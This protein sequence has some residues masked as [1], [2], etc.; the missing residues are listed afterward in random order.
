MGVEVNV[1]EDVKFSFRSEEGSIVDF[2]RCEVS[3]GFMCDVVWIVV[4]GFFCNGVMDV[5]IYDKGF[6]FVEG[7][8]LGGCWIG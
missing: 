4:V 2:S 3:F 7:V 8:D 6:V 5:E 1:V